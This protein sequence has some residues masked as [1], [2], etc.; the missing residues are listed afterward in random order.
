MRIRAQQ[1]DQIIARK[2]GRDRD[3]EDEFILARNARSNKARQRG[4]LTISV[5]T[6]PGCK[7]NAVRFSSSCSWLIL[8]AIMFTPTLDV[9][10]PSQSLVLHREYRRMNDAVN[11]TV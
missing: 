3:S 8:T 11:E 1:T 6:T 4:E 5:S 7:A 9:A 2:E 10:L